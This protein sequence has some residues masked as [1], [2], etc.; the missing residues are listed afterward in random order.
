MFK[1]K[2]EIK[3]IMVPRKMIEDP[4]LS[5]EAKGVMTYLYNRGSVSDAF[6]V[7]NDINPYIINELITKGY[8]IWENDSFVIS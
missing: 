4:D 6:I 3:Y 7:T 2:S 1:V 8:L 5:W